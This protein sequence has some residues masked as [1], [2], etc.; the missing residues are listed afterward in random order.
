M[1]F[2]AC[3]PG[4]DNIKFE[5]GAST[6]A[7]RWG[8]IL[9]ANHAA[10]TASQITTPVTPDLARCAMTQ[11]VRNRFTPNGKLANDQHNGR[12]RSLY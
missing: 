8:F 6:T 9:P 2:A 5:K 7:V 3:G 11:R 10:A 1:L 4:L 12:F